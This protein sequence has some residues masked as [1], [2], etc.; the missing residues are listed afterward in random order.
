MGG[1]ATAYTYDFVRAALPH[2]AKLILEVGCGRGELAARLQADGL[3]VVAIDSDEEAVAS[4][5]AI[6]V[7]A[8]MAVWPGLG[9]GRFDAVLFTRSLHH[10]ADL[11]GGVAAAF[12]CLEPHGRVI[13]EDFDFAF[14]DEPSF[15]WFGGLARVLA[16]SGVPLDGSDFGS[17]LTSED[18]SPLQLWHE[19][20]HHDLHSAAAILAA[21]EGPG[22]WAS[23]EGA[24]YFF[25]YLGGA[26]GGDERL[27]QALRAHELDLI[28]QGAIAP[29]GRRFVTGE[30]PA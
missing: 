29:L 26:T 18:K 2:E 4:A 10:V 15:A 17:A 3:S 30:R 12:G 24:A 9:V 5:R 13:V 6:G 22:G 27:E 25:R 20:H 16:A 8:R 23:V 19:T 28:A 1:V 21:L 11:Q 7:D 14:G